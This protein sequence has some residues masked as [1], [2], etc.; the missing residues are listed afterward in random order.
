MGFAAQHINIGLCSDVQ[1][2]AEQVSQAMDT[3][4]EIVTS[5]LT[6]GDGIDITSGVVSARVDGITIVFSGGVMQAVGAGTYSAGVALGLSTGTFNVLVD[7]TTI[8]ITFDNK[9]ES[10]VTDTTYTAGDGLQLSGTVFSAKVDGVTIDVNGSGELVAAIVIY[11]AGDAIDL[12]GG[13]INVKVDEIT[14][15][16]DGSNK[17]YAVEQIEYVAIIDDIA[18]VH[19]LMVANGD[20]NK[21]IWM[22]ELGAPTGTAS[23][24][25]SEKQQALAIGKIVEFARDYSYI[26]PIYMYSLLDTGTNLSDPEDNFGLLHTDFTTKLA[27]AIWLLDQ[28][29]LETLL[30]SLS[31]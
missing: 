24:A 21:K 13:E 26:G 23:N 22:T 5:G 8:G 12:A 19:A 15:D 29:D 18:A 1:Q 11:S 17:L 6:A 4:V 7:G 3:L 16:I 27:W 2:L 30:T 20:G 10:L 14:I 25:V 28:E 31:L 9:L